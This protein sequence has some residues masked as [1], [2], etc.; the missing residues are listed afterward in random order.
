MNTAGDEQ[1]IHK[2]ILY[3]LPELSCLILYTHFDYLAL[4]TSFGSNA[5]LFP[6]CY[7]FTYL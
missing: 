7:Y 4:M 3:F 1:A 5:V 6:T 2:V